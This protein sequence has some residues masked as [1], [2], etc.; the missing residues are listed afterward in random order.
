[1]VWGYFGR[2]T[3]C[4][5]IR[6][7]LGSKSISSFQFNNLSINPFSLAD[8]AYLDE[9]FFILK[10]LLGLFF[11]YSLFRKSGAP[12]VDAVNPRKKG[13]IIE[14]WCFMSNQDGNR[15]RPFFFLLG[16]L[17]LGAFPRGFFLSFFR[18]RSSFF[19]LPKT[20]HL[21]RC[22]GCAFGVYVCHDSVWLPSGVAQRLFSFEIDFRSSRD[23]DG[24]RV[25]KCNFVWFFCVCHALI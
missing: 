25:F 7:Y 5:C 16:R 6:L 19:H 24:S 9:P 20:F 10:V 21:I 3:W 23:F 4:T 12:D 2:P 1:M 11:T 17:P 22:C 14:V 8:R 13:F 18:F 15:R